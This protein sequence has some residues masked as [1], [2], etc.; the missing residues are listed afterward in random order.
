MSDF[1]KKVQIHPYANVDINSWALRIRMIREA[2]ELSRPKF[3]ELIGVPATSLKNYELGYREVGWPTVYALL[4]RERTR[5]LALAMF[6]DL[7]A[8]TT[9]PDLN[10]IGEV[11][12]TIPQHTGVSTYSPTGVMRFISMRIASAMPHTPMETAYINRWVN[13]FNR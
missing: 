13:C 1:K 9:C 7:P 10:S 6:V 2:L 3:A 8:L 12:Y 11:Q 4:N 5:N